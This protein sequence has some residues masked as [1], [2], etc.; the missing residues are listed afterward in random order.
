MHV[1]GDIDKWPSICEKETI[2]GREEEERSGGL[3]GN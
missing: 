2:N 1:K 3:P